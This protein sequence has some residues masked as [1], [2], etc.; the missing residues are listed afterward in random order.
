MTTSEKPAKKW[1]ALTPRQRRKE[2]LKT[3]R[4]LKSQAVEPNPFDMDEGIITIPLKPI[5]D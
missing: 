1:E 2:L 5:D 4:K 3:P